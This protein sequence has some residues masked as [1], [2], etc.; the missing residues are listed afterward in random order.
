MQI[1][2]F[3]GIIPDNKL[4]DTTKW[5]YLVVQVAQWCPT[6]CNH[7]NCNTPGFPVLQCLPESAQIHVH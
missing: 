4:S 6:L 5:A 7:M 3:S 1:C 2:I